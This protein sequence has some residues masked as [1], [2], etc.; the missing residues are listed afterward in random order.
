M[1]LVA[2]QSRFPVLLALLLNVATQL[3]S[4]PLFEQLFALKLVGLTASTND[5]CCVQLHDAVTEFAPWPCPAKVKVPDV[6]S[7]LGILMDTDTDGLLE[8]SVPPDGVKVTPL[9]LLDVDQLRLPCE[10]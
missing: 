9:K 5:G 2:D 6:Q 8:R 1:L 10:P 7:L 4:E 3:Q